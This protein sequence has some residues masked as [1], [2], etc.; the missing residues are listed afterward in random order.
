MDELR[1]G[2]FELK[3][4][5]V[6]ASEASVEVEGRTSAGGK[7]AGQVIIIHCRKVEED[8]SIAAPRRIE[9]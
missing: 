4:M 3:R 2:M 7:S 6:T 8:R 1:N 5:L 9:I